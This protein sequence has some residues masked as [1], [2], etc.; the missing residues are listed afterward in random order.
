MII[1][2][3]QQLTKNDSQYNQNILN[4]ID[5]LNYENS[6]VDNTKYY[7]IVKNVLITIMFKKLVFTDNET[8]IIV[9]INNE[10]LKLNY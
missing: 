3:L 9:I 1:N 7:L 6:L 2:K 4:Y 5:T 10:T 8:Y